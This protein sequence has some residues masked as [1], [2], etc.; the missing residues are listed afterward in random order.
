MP[1]RFPNLLGSRGLYRDG[2]KLLTSHE[3]RT[4]FAEQEW[5]LYDM[6]TDP[7]ETTDVSEQHPD[8][9]RELSKAWWDAAWH[10]TVFPMDDGSGRLQHIQRPAATR[11]DESLRSAAA[12]RRSSAADPT[13]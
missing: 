13:S 5:R 6:R 1:A 4:P 3:R 10:N 12:P 8:V 7:T 9:E 2:C 11:W